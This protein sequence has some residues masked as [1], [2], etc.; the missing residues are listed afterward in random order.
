M[1]LLECPRNMSAAASR[2][3]SRENKEDPT[4]LFMYP[5]VLESLTPTLESLTHVTLAT[6]YL[7]EVRQ[8]KLEHS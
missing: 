7:L 3:R 5:T 8:L 1:D 2:M 4:V 6:F